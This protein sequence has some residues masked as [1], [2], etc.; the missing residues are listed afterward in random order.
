MIRKIVGVKTIS[1]PTTTV[2]SPG[3]RASQNITT[4]EAAKLT[5]PVAS[6]PESIAAGKMA[7]DINC[8]ACHGNMAQGA[9]KAGVT[10]SI[11][12]EQGRKQPPD[13]TDDQWDYGS[14]DGEIYAVIKKGIPPTMMAAWDGR[15][16][17]DG[18][19]SIVNYIRTL[20][21]KK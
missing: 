4:Q 12:E 5:N 9:V 1:S 14:T 8:A 7:Y 19:W 20:A 3:P 10:I 13:L 18:I 17:D 16:P 21:P 11:I 6:T 15:I 2:S